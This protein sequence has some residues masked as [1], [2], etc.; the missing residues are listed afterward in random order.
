M[1]I[2]PATHEHGA[3]A[4]VYT[5]EA[6]YDVGPDAITWKASL[7]EGGTPLDPIAGSI[8]LTSPCLAHL[9]EEVRARR[10]RQAHRPA[11]TTRAAAPPE[12]QCIRAMRLLTRPTHIYPCDHPS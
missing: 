9:A 10:D 6:E 7:S 11:W 5:Y 1:H 4:K 3:S 2:D 8:P 12:L